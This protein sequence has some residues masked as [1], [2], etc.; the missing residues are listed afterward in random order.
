[1]QKIALALAVL[2][3]AVPAL[4][5]EKQ[6]AAPD[7]P[8]A[9]WKPP[10]VTKEA[11]NKKEIGALWKAMEAA[12]KKG[13]VKAAADLVDFPVMMMTD[14]PSTGEAMGEPWT[15]EK[16]IQV[17]EPFYKHPQPDMK[18]V[19]K[20]TIFLMS[21]AL[22]SVDDVCTLT[23]GG[24]KLTVRSSTMVLKKDGKWL[25]KAMGEGGWGD[26]KQPATAS[27]GSESGS[28]ATGQGMAPSGSESGTGAGTGH[29]TGSGSGPS[30]TGAGEA[31]QPSPTT[32]K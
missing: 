20:S 12:E 5:A 16:W 18:P 25:V 9:N 21:D 30:G 2:V 8:M 17:M 26:M 32:N 14:S 6:Q 19:H 4:A 7:N 27:Q 1:M 11:Q 22:A 10:K 3:T 24:K 28:S 31:T 23:M 15:R 13:D 29:G